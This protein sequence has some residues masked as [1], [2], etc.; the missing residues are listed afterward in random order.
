[1]QACASTSSAI[2]SV[3]LL[4]TQSSSPW[5]SPWLVTH[6]GGQPARSATPGA[7]L[8]RLVAAVNAFLLASVSGKRTGPGCTSGAGLLARSG[9]ATAEGDRAV[10]GLDL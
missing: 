2:R 4:W 6:H 5:W 7:V 10:D 9:D 3:S 1:M 8:A